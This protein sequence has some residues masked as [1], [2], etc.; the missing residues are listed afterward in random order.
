MA[1][2]QEKHEPHNLEHD[3][4]G[5][6]A[7]ATYPERWQGPDGRALPDDAPDVV[8]YPAPPTAS[9]PV[10][11]YAV[12]NNPQVPAYPPVT[13]YNEKAPNVAYPAPVANGNGTLPNGNGMLPNGNGAPLA[14]P[15]HSMAHYPAP[16][17]QDIHTTPRQPTTTTAPL[18]L[19][20]TQPETSPRQTMSYGTA[21]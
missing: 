2:W 16:G 18:P 1:R 13:S 5:R 20:V 15:D 11:T 17:Q 10:N 6:N 21:V 8:A 12:D 14:S 19:D 4:T 9:A 3:F 7:F